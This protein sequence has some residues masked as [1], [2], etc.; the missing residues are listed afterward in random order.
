[1]ACATWVQY[2]L[3]GHTA[4]NN[5]LLQLLS[6][7]IAGSIG[8]GGLLNTAYRLSKFFLG[9]YANR[10]ERLCQITTLVAWSRTV[11]ISGTWIILAMQS[12][13]RRHQIFEK[14]GLLSGPVFMLV[15]FLFYA[16]WRCVFTAHKKCQQTSGAKAEIVHRKLAP[17]GQKNFHAFALK[18]LPLQ[19][20]V[21]LCVAVFAFLSQGIGTGLMEI[22]GNANG[23][24]KQL[25]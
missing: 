10:A 17:V 25:S 3:R 9:Q 11:T 8:I 20:N 2:S 23:S 21:A 6:V 24:F 18:S 1:M 5:I 7:A 13:H 15:Y 12:D 4:A 16:Q 14:L 19:V 22:Y